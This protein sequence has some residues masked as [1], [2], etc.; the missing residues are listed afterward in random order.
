MQWMAQDSI[1]PLQGAQVRSL[2]MKIRSYMPRSM[3][4]KFFKKDVEA[5]QISIDEWIKQMW[6]IYI[7][8]ILFSLKKW[9]NL[10]LYFNMDETW[11]HYA[12][13]NK[14]VTKKTNESCKWDHTVCT[15]AE[16]LRKGSCLGLGGRVRLNKFRVYFARCKS[17]RSLL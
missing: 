10:A 2:V 17:S 1:L 7:Q 5:T 6:Y 9:G 16:L 11:G 4:K 15:V 12:K 8:W 3:A 13:W 14:L